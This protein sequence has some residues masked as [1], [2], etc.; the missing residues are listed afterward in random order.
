MV[1]HIVMFKLNENSPENLNLV[2]ST[3][4]RLEGEIETLRMIE[5]GCISINQSV[6]MTLY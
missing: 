4:N 3:L 5:L 1:K 6:P 2:L